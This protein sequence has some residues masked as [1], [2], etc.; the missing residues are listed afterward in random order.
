MSMP[1]GE[2]GE[3]KRVK[4]MRA[5]VYYRDFSQRYHAGKAALQAEAAKKAEAEAAAD[6]MNKKNDA[7]VKW[8]TC[9]EQSFKNLIP[10]IWVEINM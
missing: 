9:V 1:A 10:A 4:F 2:Q 6:M 5:A 7:D 8:A 3:D